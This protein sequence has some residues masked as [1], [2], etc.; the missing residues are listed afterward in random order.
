[1]AEI[2]LYGPFREAIGEQRIQAQGPTVRAVLATLE[3]R[4]PDLEGRLLADGDVAG[5]TVV[6]KNERDVT[7]LDGLATTV[8]E[9]DTLRLVP[10]VYGG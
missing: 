4:Y 7:H 8:S 6:T 3:E 5:S 10:S 1:M 2:I 9:D